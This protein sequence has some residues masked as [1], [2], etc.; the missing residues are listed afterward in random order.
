MKINP[1]ERTTTVKFVE[2]K[3]NTPISDRSLGLRRKEKTTETKILP[4]PG[5]NL[6]F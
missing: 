2:I 5:E 6:Y 3:R 4:Q 1:D